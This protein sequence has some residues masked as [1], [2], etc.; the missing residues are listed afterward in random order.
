[1]NLRHVIKQL[2]LLLMVL[3]TLLAL[4]GGGALVRAMFMDVDA[5]TPAAIGLWLSAGIGVIIGASMWLGSRS[6]SQYVGRRE[7]LLLVALSWFLGAALASLPFLIWAH[8]NEGI[9]ED[10]PFLNPV[11]CYFEAMSGLTTTGATVL[12]DIQS[13]PA[14]LLFWRALTHWL[15]GLGIVVLFVAVLPSVGAGAKKL[16]R[17]EAPG[18][19]PE[20]L[21]PNVRETARLLL[22]FYLG[23][24]AAAVFAFR[25]TGTMTWFESICHTFSMVSTGG[26][27]T[28]DASIGHFN[29][30][31]VDMIAIVFMLLAG[32]NFALFYLLMQGKGLSVWRD[33]E[34]RL[35]FTLKILVITI[36]TI[37]LIVM[38]RPIITTAGIEHASNFWQSLR[39]SSFTTV[40]LHT[41]TGFC[42]ADY[43][44]W[45]IVSKSLL[46]GLMFIGGCAGSTAGG[47][48]VIRMWIA[49]KVMIAQIEIAFRPQVVR[50]IKIGGQT[51]SEEMKLSAVAYVLAFPIII[52][53]GAAAIGIFEHTPADGGRC[54]FLTALSASL[55]TV[56]NVGPGL[57]AVGA[58]ENY[59]WFTSGAKCVMS[60]LMALGRLELF[61]ILVLFNT[62]F[63]RGD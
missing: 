57:A 2:G 56:S 53:F 19:S 15:G 37:D 46:V 49:M 36:V 24:S 42:S 6:S 3:S 1:M 43:D 47:V 21:R 35:Y 61:A 38:P 18:P 14:S 28:E 5:E 58:T 34:M 31:A 23:I 39:H 13:L 48:K 52:V 45:P 7:A 17:V 50:A 20:G 8:T 27:G 33:T 40:A 29:S 25:A 16:F 54:D 22:V 11:D 55:S 60:I 4:I 10:H 26:L 9:A 62:H 63:W 30:V 32:V 44:Q 12:S 41:G 51:V 59:G